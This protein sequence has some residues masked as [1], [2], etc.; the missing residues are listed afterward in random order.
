MHFLRYILP[1]AAILV[2]GGFCLADQAQLGR[3]EITHAKMT[4]SS[5]EE[6]LSFIR[7]T[8]ERFSLK[9][10]CDSRFKSTKT[11]TFDQKNVAISKFL[12]SFCSFYGLRWQ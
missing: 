7:Q 12:D 10:D 3:V 11:F 8:L 6:M 4:K 5:F 1:C 2:S 9:L